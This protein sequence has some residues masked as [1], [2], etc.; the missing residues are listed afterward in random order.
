M[1]AETNDD[2]VLFSEWELLLV[3]FMYKGEPDQFLVLCTRLYNPLCPSVGL[4]VGQSAL[5]F[6]ALRAVFCITAP[7]QMLGSAFIII[8]PAHPHVTSACVYGL[9]LFYCIFLKDRYFS[10]ILVFGSL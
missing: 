7:A 5:A 2:L 3:N 9:V 8:A 10:L 1:L 6:L 4:S